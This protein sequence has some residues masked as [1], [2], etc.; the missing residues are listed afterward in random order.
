MPCACLLLATVNTTT[1]AWRRV[2]TR[3]LRSMALVSHHRLARAMQ[4]GNAGAPGG[5]AW[6]GVK[7]YQVALRD[8]I[9]ARQSPPRRMTGLD[10]PRA[11]RLPFRSRDDSA[12][13]CCIGA[14]Y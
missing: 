3:Q 12:T 7:A 5:A 6:Q 4:Y 9:M 1:Y 13:A 14:F 10:S 8:S 11:S 2:D